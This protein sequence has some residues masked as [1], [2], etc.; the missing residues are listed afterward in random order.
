MAVNFRWGG[1][2]NVIAQIESL[3]QDQNPHYSMSRKDIGGIYD[4]RFI[5]DFAYAD[6]NGGYSASNQSFN[7]YAVA[8]YNTIRHQELQSAGSFTRNIGWSYTQTITLDAGPY[9]VLAIGAG[10]GAAATG[11]NRGG[12]GGGGGGLSYINFTLTAST[13]CKIYVG[14]PGITIYNA[15]SVNTSDG[16]C[17]GSSGIALNGVNVCAATGGQGGHGAGASGNGVNSGEESLG[18]E[19]KSLSFSFATTNISTVGAQGGGTGG[20]GGE[21]YYNGA[22]GSGGGAAGYSGNGGVGRYGNA[23]TVNSS[24][25]GGS[26]VSGTGGGGG[27]GGTNSSSCG[28]GG[29]VGIYGQGS[30]G[31]G[32]SSGLQ[33]QG[34]SGGAAG[35]IGNSSSD[36][37][38]YGGGGGA[39]DDDYNSS[40][41]YNGYGGSGAVV[42]AS[43]IAGGYPNSF[44][45]PAY[46]ALNL[47]PNGT[48]AEIWYTN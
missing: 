22:G 33:G 44:S 38:N 43:P 5:P 26:N 25:T 34:G 7:A 31:A 45:A 10:G 20:R 42:I 48:S 8:G 3:R 23:N 40:T 12:G 35:T 27:S 28:G 30:S 36:G 9:M 1:Y 41:S 19:R 2:G 32:G 13:T 39:D 37:G 24:G 18:G 6:G 21:W 16:C 46:G 14:M 11:S 29:G 4:T 47:L 15:T 17:G